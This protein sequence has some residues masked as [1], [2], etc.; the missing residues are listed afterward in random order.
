MTMPKKPT[1]N[2][3]ATTKRIV[4]HKDGTVW[5]KGKMA[6][7]VPDGYWEWFRKEGSIMRSG[8]FE[9]GKQVGKWTTYDKTGVV[10]KVT[11]FDKKKR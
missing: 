11:D 3:V 1:K 5:A 10:V 6:G 7:S 8:Y 4:R 2:K 9:K